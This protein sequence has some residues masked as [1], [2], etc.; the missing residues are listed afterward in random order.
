MPNVT[1]YGFFFF[2]ASGGQPP[3]VFN[4]QG[5]NG[6]DST[7]NPVASQYGKSGLV[8]TE[9]YTTIPVNPNGTGGPGTYTITV[10]DS[11][12]A[13]GQLVSVINQTNYPPA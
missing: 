8:F 4:I 1:Q 10:T 6:Y 7:S 2:Q 5:P 13:Q 11:D 12:G 9:A 3:Y